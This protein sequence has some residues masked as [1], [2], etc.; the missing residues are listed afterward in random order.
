MDNV[1]KLPRSDKSVII[2]SLFGGMSL[3]ESVPGY[4][5]TS[6][7]QTLNELVANCGTTRCRGYF[8]ILRK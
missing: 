5:S 2:R 4:Y 3:P 1:K 8:E 7:V 6:A